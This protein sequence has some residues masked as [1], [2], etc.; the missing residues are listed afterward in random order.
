M[1]LMNITKIKR[2]ILN[3]GFIVV[4]LFSGS[5]C[6]DFLNIVPDNTVTLDDFYTRK[7]MAWNALAKVYSFIPFMCETQQ[8][9]WL[10]GDEWIGRLDLDGNGGLMRGVRI[11]RGLQNSNDPLLGYWSGTAGGVHLYQGIRN[12]NIFLEN[13]DKAEDMTETE[14]ADWK[15]QVKFLKAYYHFLLVQEY[16]PIVIVDQSLTLNASSEDLFQ[17]RS[18]LDDCFDFIIRLMDEAIPYLKEKA[19]LTELGQVDRMVALAIKARVLLFRASPFLNGNKEYYG[20]FFDHDGLPFF[21]LDYKPEKWQ[22]ALEAVN[23]AI[24]LCETNGLGLYHCEKPPY[25][26]D[27]DD[28]ALKPDEMKTLYDLR[29]VIV[30]PWNKELIWGRTYNWGHDGLIASHSNIR[31]PEG[32]GGD[33]PNDNSFSQQWLGAT[34]NMLERYYTKNGLPLDEDQTFNRD[35]M[36]TVTNL[37][38]EADTVEYM[39]FRGLMQPGA[40]TIELY[41]NREPRFY[42]NLGFTG[43]YWRA[44]AVR[45]NTMMYFGYDGGYT[46]A[47]SNEN[48]LC[49]GVG[50]QKFVHPESKSGHSARI[51]RF[52]YPII[53]MADLYLMKAEILNEI[54]GSTPD[55]WAEV[56]KIRNRAGLPN[57]EDVY[58]NDNIVRVQY[59]DKHLEKDGMREIILRE[60]SIELAF[61]GSRFWDMH[62]Y[63]RAITE[64]STP[65]IGWNPEGYNANRFFVLDLKQ[66]RRFLFRD[67]LWPISL[68]ERNTNSNIIQNPGW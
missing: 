27:R 17:R 52:P 31:L 6:K 2:F 64:F 20:D 49:T 11:M 29:M 65:M 36:Y 18:K 35:A 43:G 61:E 15:A 46:P 51:I 48:Y 59:R 57:V 19:G 55:V 53:R 33:V 54:G 58:T 1:K 8:S 45:I 60:R 12:A 50:V 16:G 23:A 25:A 66:S 32:Y 34:Y 40:E 13:I 42:A 24:T 21:P 37:P 68:N 14:L 38:G 30:D 22:D 47:Y 56:N 10:L 62:R 39:P 9:Q 41:L 3:T 5:S 44:H 26:Y 7:E 28:F 4:M 67:C 63:R